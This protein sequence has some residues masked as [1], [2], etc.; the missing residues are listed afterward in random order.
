MHWLGHRTILCLSF[1]ESSNCYP[2]WLSINF[3]SAMYKGSFFFPSLPTQF[4]LFWVQSFWCAKKYSIVTIICISLMIDA[5]KYYY[6]LVSHV[7]IFLRE[8]S[9]KFFVH[10][11]TKLFV[12]LFLCYNNC[13]F[14][15]V[16]SSPQIFDLH[17]FSPILFFQG[18]TLFI[19]F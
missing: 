9:F 19:Y 13:S 18:Y 15:W 5:L 17:I 1:K 7:Y 16:L 12:F 2:Q 4:F 10:F 6:V 11:K 3:P 14:T 8:T